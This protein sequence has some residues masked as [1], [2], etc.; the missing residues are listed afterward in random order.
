[1]LHP[2]GYTPTGPKTAPAHMKGFLDYTPMGPNPPL[3]G[4]LHLLSPVP[5]PHLAPF[6]PL[7]RLPTCTRRTVNNDIGNRQTTRNLLRLHFP[8]PFIAAGNP[9]SNR[10]EGA[11]GK[12]TAWE[13]THGR[14]KLTVHASTLREVH[15]P[16][17][18]T[19]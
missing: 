11:K 15:R 8:A 4:L 17:T 7:S 18:K 10:A 16:T 6:A 13:R 5:L 9:A 3:A 19:L 14:Q 2:R 12:K 1:M